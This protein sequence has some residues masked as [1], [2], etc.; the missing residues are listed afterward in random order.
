MS[1]DKYKYIL[2]HCLKNAVCTRNRNNNSEG[3]E[4]QY[5]EIE[6][7]LISL[8]NNGYIYLQE[9]VIQALM[10]L[11]KIFKI[12]EVPYDEQAIRLNEIMDCVKEDITFYK[13]IVELIAKE[14]D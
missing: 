5:K 11:K 3:I 13:R 8:E 9:D 12:K 14:T 4:E 10:N 7:K 2:I 1:E 6:N